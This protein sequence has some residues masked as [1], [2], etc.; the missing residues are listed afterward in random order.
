MKNN[1]FIIILIFII[2][3]NSTNAQENNIALTKGKVEDAK[4]Q[5]DADLLDAN[6]NTKAETWYLAAY[7][8][9]RMAKSEVYN[10]LEAFPGEKA[11]V[12][13]QNSMMIDPNREMYSEQI[14]VLLDLGP[15]F[16]NKAINNYNK[17]LKDSTEKNYRLAL[18]Y[19]ED[20]FKLLYTLKDEQ[21]YVRQ[22]I[23]FS[24]VN[25]D[26]IYF[27]TGYSAEQVGDKTKALEHYSKLI[28]YTSSKVEAKQKGKDLAYLYTSNIYLSNKEYDKA[29]KVIKRGVELFPENDNLV[30][31]AIII[32]NEAE[33]T[34]DMINQMEEVVQNNPDNIKLRFLLARN[35]TTYG[36]SFA[37]N[38]YQATSDKYYSKATDYYSQALNLNPDNKKTMYSINYNFGV[39]YY[40]R[41]VFEYKKG[42]K[43]DL[44]KLQEYFT[45]AKPFLEKANS[46]K[47]NSNI[48]KMILKINETIGE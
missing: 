32:Y 44:N 43:A 45:K 18:R 22:I 38:G 5:V 16:Y 3:I 8:Y 36:K 12:Y 47:Q 48:D 30:M 10:H 2:S 37:K 23:E 17:A 7:V 31:T 29:I 6:K 15:A 46:V 34:D 28:D 14:N 11:L 26:D 41:G 24:G 13:I 33:K 9:T 42:N 25:A 19:F 1:Y 27:Y 4:K 39:L 40:N 21:K 35:Y 20:Y